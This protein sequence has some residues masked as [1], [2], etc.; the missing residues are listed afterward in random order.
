MKIAGQ[1]EYSPPADSDNDV[2]G[3][4]ASYTPSGGPTPTQTAGNSGGS[5][6]RAPA[7]NSGGSAGRANAQGGTVPSVQVGN[8]Y[9]TAAV[10]AMPGTLRVGDNKNVSTPVSG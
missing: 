3:G 1:P 9:E 8:S 7:G 5:A 10:P 4:H 6:G 2:G